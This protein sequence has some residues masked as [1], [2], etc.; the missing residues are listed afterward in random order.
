MDFA[1]LER[2]CCWIGKGEKAGREPSSLTADEA[3]A[4]ERVKRD[5][6]RLEQEKIPQEFALLTLRNEGLG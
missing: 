1:T 2:F 6:I 5:G 3:A 4:Y